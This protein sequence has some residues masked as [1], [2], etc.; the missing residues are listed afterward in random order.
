MSILYFRK[1]PIARRFDESLLFICAKEKEYSTLP[2]DGPIAL[3]S[4]CLHFAHPE[5]GEVL[6]FEQ[7]PPDCY[8][9]DL[10]TGFAD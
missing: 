7:Q 6:Y 9:W 1:L 8:P 3:W 5:T 2:D 4:H 10:F